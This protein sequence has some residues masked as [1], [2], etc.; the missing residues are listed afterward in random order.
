MNAFYVSVAVGFIAVGAHKYILSPGWNIPK[1]MKTELRPFLQ[2]ILITAAGGYF[3]HDIASHVGQ[4]AVDALGKAP[5]LAGFTIG[6]LGAGTDA[7]GVLMNLVG[8]IPVI[9]PAITKAFEKKAPPT[10]PP[11]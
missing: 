8:A 10:D 3:A 5:K 11:A 9:G 6:A 4:E 7:L 2:A 1:W